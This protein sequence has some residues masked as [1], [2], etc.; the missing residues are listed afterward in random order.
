MSK[1]KSKNISEKINHSLDG[2][3]A[4]IQDYSV[5]LAYFF[6]LPVSIL[7]F[8][9]APDLRTKLLSSFI[10]LFWIVF[11]SLNTSLETIVD[12]IS[13][14]KHPLSKIA[15]DIP[16]FINAIIVLFFI[17][18]IV[19]LSFITKYGYDDWRDN[20]LDGS[21]SDYIHDSFKK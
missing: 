21:M 10:F 17:F 6:S 3:H 16:S 19:M 7:F 18:A 2:F 15:K 5:R 11:E 12:R 20:N 14:R 1:Y 13:M 8:I 9:F 4:S